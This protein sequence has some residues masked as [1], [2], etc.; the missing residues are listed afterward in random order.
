[1]LYLWFPYLNH[2][3]AQVTIMN[4]PQQLTE[5][6]MIPQRWS[7]SGIWPRRWGPGAGSPR[8]GCSPPGGTELWSFG[9]WWVTT[10]LAVSNMTWNIFHN[11]W[12][13]H[14]NPSHWLIFF[15]KGWNH[16][17]ATIDPSLLGPELVQG[18]D[19]Q[20]WTWPKWGPQMNMPLV[21]TSWGQ[22][23]LWLRSIHS[24]GFKCFFGFYIC[25]RSKIVL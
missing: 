2:G 17:P 20:H 18:K 8:P 14:D 23:P 12:D 25:S 9:G 15:R 13:N 7:S 19:S 11:I 1:M 16:Q 4:S 5:V 3:D 24:M 22:P 6:P 10:W 21:A